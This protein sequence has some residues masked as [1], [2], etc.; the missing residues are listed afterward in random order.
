MAEIN[1]EGDAL[2]GE[3]ALD[4]FTIVHEWSRQWSVVLLEDQDPRFYK[5]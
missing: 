1:E 3:V 4:M 5:V 2:T